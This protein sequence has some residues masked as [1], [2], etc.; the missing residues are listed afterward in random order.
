MGKISVGDFAEAQIHKNAASIN[1][2]TSSTQH[3]SEIAS[4]KV[5]NTDDVANYYI[6]PT[7]SSVVD[8]LSGDYFEVFAITDSTINRKVQYIYIL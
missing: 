7:V 8:A 4:S 3:S 6:Q 2:T 5:Y 1:G